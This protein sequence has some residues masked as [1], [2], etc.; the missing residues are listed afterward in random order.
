MQESSRNESTP[1]SWEDD[2][3]NPG[4]APGASEVQENAAH[5]LPPGY[6]A[7]PLWGFRDETGRFSYQFH[8]VY[9]PPRR[10]DGRGPLQ[11]LDEQRSYW[12]VTWPTGVRTT[13]EHLEGRS[14]SYAQARQLRG[15]NLTFERFS[16]MRYQLP[17]LLE[18]GHASVEVMPMTA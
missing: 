10:R 8:H 6:E 4:P 12:E 5:L 14:M 18:V 13:D 9:G 11:E 17:E 2:G 1:G 3:G 16:S 15:P 7:Q